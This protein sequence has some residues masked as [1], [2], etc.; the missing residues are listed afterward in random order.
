MFLIVG[1]GNPGK[2][3]INNRHNIGYKIINEIKDIYNFPIFNKKFYSESSKSEIDGDIIFLIKPT[4]YMNNSGIAVK[5]FKEFYN[6]DNN[7]IYVIHDEIDLD[8]GRIKIKV[9]GGH[10]GHNGIKSIDQFVGKDYNRVRVG[11]SRP[12]KI[13]ENNVDENISSWVLSNFSSD[14]RIKWV[15]DTINKVAENIHS[16]IKDKDIF[17]KKFRNN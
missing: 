7:N 2:T 8:Q 3:Y 11:V 12:S 9:G 5:K 16:L 1:L 15:N 4:T 14:E 6:V 10:N 17:L 13:Y